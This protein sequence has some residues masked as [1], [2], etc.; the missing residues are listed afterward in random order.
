M[1]AKQE[2]KCGTR[3]T[4]LQVTDTWIASDWGT[5]KRNWDAT[6][7]KKKMLMGAGIIVRDHAGQVVAIKCMAWPYV[8]DPTVA[9][10]MAVKTAA[11]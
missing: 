6:I 7:D 2:I 9:E 3:Q 1:K 8:T 11:E 4:S 5:V 10:A